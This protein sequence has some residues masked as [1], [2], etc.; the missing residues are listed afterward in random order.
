MYG[1][2]GW[3]KVDLENQGIVGNLGSMGF[4]E[5]IQQVNKSGQCWKIL[6][7]L[8]QRVRSGMHGLVGEQVQNGK[9][10]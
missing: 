7:K 4:R 6:E 3:R 8:D 9:F 10:S 5:L 2:C 1:F